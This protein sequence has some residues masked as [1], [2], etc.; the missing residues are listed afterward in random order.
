MVFPYKPEKSDVKKIAIILV[1]VAFSLFLFYFFG[2]SQTGFISLTEP[3]NNENEIDKKDN[4]LLKEEPVTSY[5]KAV[6]NLPI[7]YEILQPTTIKVR[8]IEGTEI[9]ICPTY[10]KLKVMVEN[11]GAFKA[12]AILL[13]T[14]NGE[15]KNCDN[16]EIIEVLKTKEKNE[17]EIEACKEASSEI[18]TLILSFSAVNSEAFELKIN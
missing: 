5:K 1:A 9:N 17:I 16:C 13:K 3:G 2:N 7:Y 4:M 11:T 18:K 14:L 12:E 8:K 6:G 10:S 15:V